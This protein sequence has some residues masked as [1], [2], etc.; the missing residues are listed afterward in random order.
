[1]TRG[2]KRGN[3]GGTMEIDLN[4]N[5]P[6]GYVTYPSLDMVMGLWDVD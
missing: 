2:A 5:V 1:M 6:T 3:Y 4:A